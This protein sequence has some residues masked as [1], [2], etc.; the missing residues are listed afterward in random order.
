MRDSLGATPMRRTAI[1]LITAFAALFALDR[2]SYF[3]ARRAL[4][5]QFPS[6]VN[7]P[8]TGGGGLARRPG[9]TPS[10]A[11]LF[12]FYPKTPGCEDAQMWVSVTGQVLETHPLAPGI[13]E[14]VRCV[15]GG[16]T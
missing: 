7:L 6:L 14:W 13:P 10:V 16:I 12:D 5:K 15:R 1:I 2:L 11:W 8:V 3:G 9:Q 4:Y